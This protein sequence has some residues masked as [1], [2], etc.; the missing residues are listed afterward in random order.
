VLHHSRGPDRYGADTGYLSVLDTG[1]YLSSVINNDMV[2]T[3]DL[4]DAW[5]R[6]GWG[7]STPQTI[8]QLAELILAVHGPNLYTATS[9]DVLLACSYADD[10]W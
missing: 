5:V 9:Y 10:T 3:S 6:R 8:D 2:Y 4:V 1:L 7:P